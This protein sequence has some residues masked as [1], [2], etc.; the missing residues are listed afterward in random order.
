MQIEP[1]IGEVSVVLRGQFNPAIFSPAWFALNKLL[2]QGLVDGAQL[3]ICSGEI[4]VFGAEW[5]RIEVDQRRFLASTLQAPSVRVCD[6]VARTFS[7][8][9]YHT[10]L[11]ALGINRSVHFC[12]ESLSQRDRMGRRIAPVE[13]W[14]AWGKTLGETGLQGGVTSLTMTQVEIEG[15]P[16]GDRIHVTTQPSNKVGD[17][18]KGV[19]VNVND[20]YTLKET[21]SSGSARVFMDMLRERFSSSITHSEKIIDHIMSL[22]TTNGTAE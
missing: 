16:P 21:V 12:V 11:E 19:L 22:A 7:E 14:G 17:G 8:G 18:V 20:H 13:P 2:G 3:E 5:L 6:L 9:L 4:T 1:E 15:R 10:P